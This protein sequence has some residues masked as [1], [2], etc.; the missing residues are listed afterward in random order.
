ML[1]NAY[2]VKCHGKVNKFVGWVGRPQFSNM[3]CD[4]YTKIKRLDLQFNV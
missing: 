3:V 2:R 4:C 1:T